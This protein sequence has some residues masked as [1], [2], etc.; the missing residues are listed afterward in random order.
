MNHSWKYD[1]PADRAV[2]RA[3]E[4]CGASGR[5]YRT[6]N[7]ATRWETRLAGNLPWT[8]GRIP[9]CPAERKSSY[10][11]VRVLLTRRLKSEGI[12]PENAEVELEHLPGDWRKSPTPEHPSWLG[13]WRQEDARRMIFS[14][15]S[16]RSCAEA[17]EIRMQ[18]DQVIPLCNGQA[19][20]STA[21]RILGIGE[22]VRSTA[23]DRDRR[24]AD[25][26][27]A[28]GRR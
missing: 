25:V 22:A 13:K 20:G 7:G 18:G 10:A 6:C 9:P 21:A 19:A 28:G 11:S 1:G 14:C 16:M 15:H 24:L 2:A 17:P 26:L 5:R 8:T 27:S 23:G 3:C 12:V 4:L